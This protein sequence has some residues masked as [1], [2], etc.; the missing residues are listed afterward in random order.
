MF[1][2]KLMP[3][4]QD[5]G[6]TRLEAYR[7]KRHAD[8][9]P[10]PFGGVPASYPG[11]P[12]RFMIHHHAARQTHF[13]LRLEMEGVLRSWAI[14]KGPSPAVK[15]KRFA[16]LVEDHPIE[17]GEFE[18]RIPDGNYGAGW[19]IV[20]D[21]G[22][23]IPKGDPVEGLAKGKILFELRGQ[24][25]HGTWTLV[26]MKG[27]GKE[28]D[29]DKQWL[30]IKEYDSVSDESK[31][32]NDYSMGSVLSGYS[33]DDLLQEKNREAEVI[34]KIRKLRGSV[35]IPVSRSKK[36]P[37]PMLASTAEPFSKKGWLFEIKYDGYRLVCEK[38]GP[39]V[40]LHSR[41]GND[42]SA[43]F[44]EVHSAIQK[45]PYD[46]LVIDGEVVVHAASGLPSF[47]RLQKRG[48]LT[49]PSAVSR[50]MLEHPATYYAFDLLQFAQTDLRGIKLID[51]KVILKNLL[52]DPGMI[53]FS[54]HIEANGNAMYQ[55]AFDLGLEG[56]VAKK[57]TSKYRHG[58]SD[59]WLKIRVD[60]SDDFVVVGYKVNQGALR[61]I[62]VGQFVNGTL[63]YA[64]NVGS[65]KAA[66]I[67][68]LELE[69]GGWEWTRS[70]VSTDLDDLQITRLCACS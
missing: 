36:P 8:G 30:F 35:P 26:R 40:T 68:V 29:Q 50:A 25:L 49:R 13:D 9:T 6:D 15:D 58:R 42:L 39:K 23:Y 27:K 22:F 19:T 32:T 44:P 55:A 69:S 48:R 63:T 21:K 2:K 59:E 52:P 3:V 20:W 57:A 12:L 56:I 46:H 33:L 60:H 64:G 62:A 18:G 61:S 34:A 10:E 1:K 37:S 66:P 14:P 41:N 54:D 47:S 31:T 17:Y 51:R 24:K 43:A 4:K 28:T 38:H 7:R 70:K 16:A 11:A 53:R 67:G 65:G 45:L 5:A